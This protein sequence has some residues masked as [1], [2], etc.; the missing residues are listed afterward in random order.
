MRRLNA[1][2]SAAA[3][4]LL[5]CVLL[6]QAV[7]SAAPLFRAT[8]ADG[9]V[10]YLLGTMHSD[11]P[12]VVALVPRVAKLMQG[13]EAVVLEMLPDPAS[14]LLVANAS[15]LPAGDS[16]LDQVGE[17]RRAAL[18]AAAVQR[19]LPLVLIDRLKPW[20]AAVTLSMPTQGGGAFLDLA[21][22]QEA[23][24]QGRRVIGLETAPEQLALFDA[25]PAALQTSLLDSVIKNLDQVPQQTEELTLAYLSGDLERLEQ[26]AH[27][28][29]GDLPAAV[30]RWFRDDLVEQRNRRMAGRLQRLLDG[31][32]A[33]VAVGALHLGGESGLL[34]QLRRLGFSVTPLGL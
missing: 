30:E 7:A 28:R 23:V 20:A 12:R 33:L 5:S 21:L 31:R 18:E 15:M 29:Y 16:L 32:P 8:H 3:A 26:V 22:Y 1:I 2:R 24:R 13:V 19:G 25:M 11:D 6:G 14:L 27:G 9:A 10:L 34:A 17:G 4:C